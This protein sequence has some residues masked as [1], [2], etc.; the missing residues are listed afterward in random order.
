MTI[1]R[2]LLKLWNSEIIDKTG[3]LV[4]ERLENVSC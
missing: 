2:Q 4:G 3:V 1:E